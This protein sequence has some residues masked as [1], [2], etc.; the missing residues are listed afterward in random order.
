MTKEA[1]D[2]LKDAANGDLPLEQLEEVKALDDEALE[3]V[4][5]GFSYVDGKGW[6]LEEGK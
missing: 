3:Q 5:G 1:L 6:V 4:A 2:A